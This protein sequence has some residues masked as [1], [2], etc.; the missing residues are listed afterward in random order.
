MLQGFGSSHWSPLL[1]PLP[2]RGLSVPPIPLGTGY[3]CSCRCLASTTRCRYMAGICHAGGRLQTGNTMRNEMHLGTLPGRAPGGR[4]GEERRAEQRRGEEKAPEGMWGHS[5][6]RGSVRTGRARITASQN[7]AS[8][9]RGSAGEPVD[10]ATLRGGSACPACLCI[11]SASPLY[12]VSPGAPAVSPASTVPG[13][14]SWAGKLVVVEGE[15]QS[16]E[17]KC[18]TQQQNNPR[19]H[20]QCRAFNCSWIRDLDVSVGSSLQRERCSKRQ[21]GE[22]W[23]D[24]GKKTET[25]P[26]VRDDAA[27]P[28]PERCSRRLPQLSE[29]PSTIQA[30]CQAVAKFLVE[31]KFNSLGVFISI[32][33][34]S[35][36]KESTRITCFG[37]FKIKEIFSYGIQL[38]CGAHG[39]RVWWEQRGITA[40]LPCF[41]S[42]SV[43]P[44]GLREQ[45]GP[46]APAG[47]TQP[48]SAAFP[49]T[50]FHVSTSGVDFFGAALFP[51]LPTFVR[52]WALLGRAPSIHPPLVF[53]NVR[54]F[55]T[56]K[57]H[58]TVKS[59]PILHQQCLGVR[60]RHKR[61]HGT[62][63]HL[64]TFTRCQRNRWQTSLGTSGISSP[65]ANTDV[66]GVRGHRHRGTAWWHCQLLG[67]ALEKVRLHSPGSCW[68]RQTPAL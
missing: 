60:G 46:A 56:V 38:N 53:G 67:L 18:H 61:P 16:D 14:H 33:H 35:Q 39:H 28:R 9:V 42:F 52:R 1:P 57:S 62:Y 20:T 8:A 41:C 23:T 4:K 40:H 31:K 22:R 36:N 5:S 43:Y 29:G 50:L 34:V 58:S 68:W 25:T 44:W 48:H 3:S 6:A 11:P 19:V 27:E 10:M 32:H 30:G 12:P 21:R 26:A 13:G 37:R 55:L 51:G 2:G 7:A 63:H 54:V 15:M 59:T 64:G 47:F 17:I 49:S 45:T 24:A 66:G 65:A